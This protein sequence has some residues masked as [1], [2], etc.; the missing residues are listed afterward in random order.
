VDARWVDREAG[1][2]V[3]EA[4]EDVG[5]VGDPVRAVDV[6]RRESPDLPLQASLPEDEDGAV[7]VCGRLVR[8]LLEG[9]H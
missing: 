6:E 8:R 9:E 7:R 3:A 1:E 5:L 2:G 4:G